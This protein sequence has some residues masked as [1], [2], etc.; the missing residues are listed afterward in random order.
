MNS[1]EQLATDYESLRSTGGYVSLTGQPKK[2]KAEMGGQSIG[3]LDIYNLLQYDC[4]AILE[5]FMT[6]RSDD[7]RSKRLV[8]T[9]IIQNGSCTMPKNTGDAATKNL[10]NIHMTAMGLNV[11]Q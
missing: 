5:E 2:G 11:G 4:S 6:V 8:I 7:F 1:L 3:N 9:D 10:Y